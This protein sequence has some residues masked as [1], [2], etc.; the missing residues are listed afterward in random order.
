MS[1]GIFKCRGN[2]GSPGTK[3]TFVRM[4]LSHTNATVKMFPLHIS[5]KQLHINVPKMTIF[6]TDTVWGI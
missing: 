3:A 1:L 5:L 4:T 2:Y 6:V